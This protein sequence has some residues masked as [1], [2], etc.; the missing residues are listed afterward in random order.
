MVNILGENFHPRRIALVGMPNC[1]KTALFNKLTGARQKIANY[2]GVTVE[3]K[4]GQ[5]TLDGETFEILDLPGL[6]SF[7]ATSHDEAITRDVC[8]GNY[9]GEP[10]PDFIVCVVD[11]TNLQLHLRFVVE[12][13]ELGI[14]MLIA[15]NM[16][17]LAKK[18]GIYIDQANLSSSLG[19]PVVSTTTVQKNGIADLLDTLSIQLHQKKYVPCTES[20]LIYVL[21]QKDKTLLQ[22]D[23]NTSKRCDQFTKESVKINQQIKLILEKSVYFPKNYRSLERKIDFFILN[24]IFGP[25]ILLLFL[26]F[27][28]QAVFSWAQPFKYA[29]ER[30]IALGADY[31]LSF[32]PKSILKDFLAEGIFAGLGTVLAFLPQILIL[33]FF[34]FVLE[35][36]GY[37]P[38]AAYLL[39]K[40]M[41]KFGLSGRS[42]IPLLSSFACVIPG[43]MAAR[44]IPNHK[45]R[46]ITILVAPLATCSAR[47]PIYTLLIGT[48]VPKRSI[49]GVFNLSGIVLFFVYILGIVSICLT[50][51]VFKQCIARSES[52]TLLLELPP[53]RLPRLNDL[54]ISLYNR[55]VAFLSKITGLLVSLSVLLWFFVSF[56]RP[57][58]EA[59]HP[60]IEYSFAGRIGRFL[61]PVFLPIGFDWRIVI[62]LIPTFA[63]R[64]AIISALATVYAVSSLNEVE[65]LERLSTLI[66]QDWSLPTAFSLLVWFV[67]A[68]QCISTLA[69]IRRETQ[70]VF[71][72][73]TLTC[74]LVVLAYSGSF[75]TYQIANFLINR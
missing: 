45:D 52:S 15:L 51:W 72:T 74:Y 30:I 39:D 20:L 41:I 18:K 61:S 1:G 64:E 66:Y 73:F 11:V 71:F 57:P 63:A 27:I 46:L 58:M 10:P 24:P 62:A 4:S 6:Y 14:P 49:F 5:R 53:Y 8:M 16:V 67:F 31:L 56:P 55:A 65:T 36:S 29:I 75:L 9:K 34:I 54:V 28:F 3:R 26:F 43:V 13:M 60:A 2:A 19:V 70:S 17:D 44:N 7:A 22:D 12:V 50:S 47:L 23:K 48:F 25:I 35:E 69:I 38:R 21:L 59:I 33:F 42:F 37:L 68:P 40:S 32:L